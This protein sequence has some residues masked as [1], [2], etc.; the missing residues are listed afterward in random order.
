[1][2]D[3]TFSPTP[4]DGGIAAPAPALDETA[5]QALARQAVEIAIRKERRL[6][7]I[8]GPQR[9]E[10]EVDA[11]E[12]ARDF[13]HLTP[14]GIKRINRQRQHRIDPSIVLTPGGLASAL[15]NSLRDKRRMR[16]RRREIDKQRVAA[17]VDAGEIACQRVGGDEAAATTAG[18]LVAIE[19]HPDADP[20]LWTIAQQ[21][22]D[23]TELESA[24]WTP[25]ARVRKPKPILHLKH[26]ASPAGGA[27]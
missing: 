16:K 3:G 27:P 15:I 20:L 10:A 25:P 5:I 18:V 11:A 19:L 17:G 1:M 14:R 6:R 23:A 22:R 4:N 24:A 12:I 9:L 8:H 13:L 26:P 21:E 2:A 7:Q